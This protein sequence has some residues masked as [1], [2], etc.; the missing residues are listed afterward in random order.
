MT[1]LSSVEFFPNRGRRDLVKNNGAATFMEFTLAQSL[2]VRSMSFLQ[3]VFTAA[4]CTRT[5]RTLF[6]FVLSSRTS[7]ATFCLPSSLVTSADTAKTSPAHCFSSA[8]RFVFSRGFKRLPTTTTLIP[9]LASLRVKARPIPDPPP[10]TT[11]SSLVLTSRLMGGLY[12]PKAS[13]ILGAKPL[14]VDSA[15]LT[16]FVFGITSGGRVG[17]EWHSSSLASEPPQLLCSSE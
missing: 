8:V 14:T 9:R 2:V 11:A 16:Q 12:T 6:F 10:V 13:A 7:S 3:G 1:R 5:R 17:N 15:F 4:L